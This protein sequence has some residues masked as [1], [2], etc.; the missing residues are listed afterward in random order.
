MHISYVDP[1]DAGV[2]CSL[3][4]TQG[5]SSRCG[6]KVFQIKTRIESQQAI[7]NLGVEAANIPGY[8]I[9]LL[10][11]Y[12]ARNQQGTGNQERG[13]RPLGYPFAQL[14]EIIQSLLIRNAA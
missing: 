2:L 11:I 1:V 7:R 14:P 13:I 9:H 12:I 6:R 3:L 4:A 8:G 10:L 5:V